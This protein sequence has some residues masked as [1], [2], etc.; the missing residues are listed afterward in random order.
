M[1]ICSLTVASSRCQ[2]KSSRC[3]SST[4]WEHLLPS[5]DLRFKGFP[6][7]GAELDS[8]GSVLAVGSKAAE[9][10]HATTGIKRGQAIQSAYIGLVAQGNVSLSCCHFFPMSLAFASASFGCCCGRGSEPPLQGCQLL[11]PP[12]LPHPIGLPGGMKSKTKP[13]R[14]QDVV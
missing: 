13:A 8:E 2:G 6:S 11:L 7:P 9:G 12:G 3:C 1:G 10:R 14:V 4:S 5:S